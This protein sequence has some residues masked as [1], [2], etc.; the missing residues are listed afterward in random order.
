MNTV[1]KYL[2][3]LEE[4]KSMKKLKQTTAVIL[5]LVLIISAMAGQLPTG[6]AAAATGYGISNPWT[7]SGLHGKGTCHRAGAFRGTGR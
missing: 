1:L 6:S 2:I 5:S 3:K 4:R 7:D